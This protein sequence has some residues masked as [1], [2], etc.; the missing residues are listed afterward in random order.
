LLPVN[1]ESGLSHEVTS[2]VKANVEIC[3]TSG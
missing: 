1:A 3:P 2:T